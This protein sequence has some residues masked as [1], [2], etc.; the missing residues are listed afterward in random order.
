VS[1]HDYNHPI[2]QTPIE[3][4]KGVGPKRGELLRKHLAIFTF[5]DLLYHIP[6]RYVD[7]SKYVKVDELQSDAVEVQLVGK[8]TGMDE[9]GEGRKKRL[10]VHFQDDSGTVELVWFQGA[11]WMK[12]NLKMGESYVAFGKPNRFK[13]RWSIPH[14]EMELLVEHQRSAMSGLMPMYS[15]AD[16]LVKVGLTNRAI[17]KLIQNLLPQVKG[18]LAEFLPGYVLEKFHLP[19]REAAMMEIHFPRN[20]EQLEKARLRLKFEELLLIQLSLVAQRDWRKREL[21]SHLFAQVGEHFNTFYNQHLPF[22]LTNAQKRVIKEIRQDLGRGTQMNRLLQGDVGSGKTVVALMTCLL[23]KDNGFQSTILAPTEILANQHYEGLKELLREMPITV[24]L[25]TGST[26][27]AQRKVLFEDLKNGTLD[28][29][30][31][32]HAVL[33]DKVQFHNLGLVIFDEQHRFGVAQ[34]AAMW[35]KSSLT[36]H[37]LVM[38]A[39]PIPRTL[40]MSLY[41]DLDLS[42]IDELPPG[43]KPIQTIHKTDSHRLA[44]F[45]FMRKQIEEGRQVYVVFPLIE[46][47]EALELKD[48]VDG[49]ES[50]VREFPEPKYQVGILHGRL[51][52][53]DKDFEMQRFVKNQTQI[54]VATTVIEVG[55]NVPNAT[56]MVIESA[57]RFGL[58]QLHQ[59]R[60][61]VGRGGDQSYCIL[62]TKESLNP[63][64]Y[65]RIQT[66]VQTQDGFEIAEVDMQLRGPGDMMGTQQSGLPPLK[67]ADLSKD[68]QIVIWAR[69][70]AEDLLSADPQL[71]QANHLPLRQEFLRKNKE[72]I[73]WSRIS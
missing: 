73:H 22:E 49:Y 69:N 57:E 70:I 46:E 23:A 19:A 15:S 2:L 54:L 47:S 71:T 60:G 52:A 12:D 11:K 36:P 13:S 55:V 68:R 58:S 62:M 18:T 48:L 25:L 24:A 16:P 7:R 65:K 39:T 35:K 5:G 32:T 42:V 4:L 72:K 31:G 1:A 56:V 28:I 44:L 3:Y 33:E 20:T 29:L 17:G 61:R 21:K 41:G 53:A 9:M 38:T 27:T 14:P 6:Y 63:D 66:M 67:I 51:K 10:H 40:S 45:G 26:T 59:L 43:R 30:I 34:R 50:I 8:I 37:V 64:A